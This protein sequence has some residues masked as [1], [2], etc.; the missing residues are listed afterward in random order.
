MRLAP[1]LAVA[2]L[3]AAVAAATPAAAGAGFDYD[4]L[5]AEF[6]RLTVAGDL[7]HLRPLLSR[8]LAAALDRAAANPAL[9][10]PAVLFQTYTTPVARCTA[11][12]INAALVRITRSQPDGTGWNDY[13]VVVPEPDG[14]TRIDDVLFAL[15]KS[16]TLMSRLQ[17]LAGPG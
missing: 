7:A 11:K 4:A 12:T 9:P 17:A 8:Q 15:R 13:I 2:S 5:G 3:A 1:A 6:C 14:Q 10:P 16:D